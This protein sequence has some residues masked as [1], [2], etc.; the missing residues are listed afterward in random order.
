MKLVE[1]TM[2]SAA[3]KRQYSSVLP[4]LRYCLPVFD[5]ICEMATNFVFFVQVTLLKTAEC[6][7][8]T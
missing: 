2:L 7:Y 4:L 3:T 5:E 6:G 1:S 8:T